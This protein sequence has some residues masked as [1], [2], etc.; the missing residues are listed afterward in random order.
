MISSAALDI[1]FVEFGSTRRTPDFHIYYLGIAR[2]G[3]AVPDWAR[4]SIFSF[5]ASAAATVMKDQFRPATGY[6]PE[7]LWPF[8]S[9]GTGCDCPS[10]C[11]DTSELTGEVLAVCSLDGG[12]QDDTDATDERSL[13]GPSVRR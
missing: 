10:W 11:E 7:S 2:R 3:D 4:G 9:E 6:D 8:D 5:I 1:V 13:A 12:E